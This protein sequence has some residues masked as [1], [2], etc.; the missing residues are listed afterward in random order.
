MSHGQPALRLPLAALDPGLRAAGAQGCSGDMQL[1]C[2]ATAARQQASRFASLAGR[3]PAPH[4]APK[5]RGLLGGKASW[6]GFYRR[7]ATGLTA[8]RSGRVPCIHRAQI[9]VAPAVP[10]LAPVF[11]KTPEPVRVQANCGEA[12]PP[13]VTLQNRQA[14]GIISTCKGY[15]CPPPTAGEQSGDRQR[16]EKGPPILTAEKG[17]LR[18]RTIACVIWP[19]LLRAT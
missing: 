14:T 6:P 9:A 15:A 10:R 8:R 17:E 4:T 16:R 5:G 11:G 1:G 7:S 3:C 19:T 18:A 2:E 13:F 12:E